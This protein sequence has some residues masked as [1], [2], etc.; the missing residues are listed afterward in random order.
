MICFHVEKVKLSTVV[1]G[2]S[3]A[4]FSNAPKLLFSLDFS[5]LPFIYTLPY[6]VKQVVSSNTFYVFGMTRPG[7][8]Y[9]VSCVIGKHSTHETS[10]QFLNF[11]DSFLFMN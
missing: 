8:K 2:D 6:N 7:I 9:S 4:L 11:S 3:K 10:I 5:T 1:E